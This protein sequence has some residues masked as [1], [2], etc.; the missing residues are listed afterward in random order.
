[1]SDHACGGG[2]GIAHNAPPCVNP[3]K[4]MLLTGYF[5]SYKNDGV[6]NYVIFFKKLC[7]TWLKYFFFSKINLV[8]ARKK[9]FK[10]FFSFSKSRLHANGTY[11]G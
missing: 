5:C 1:M 7:K 10:I 8:T 3:D 11:T 9:I 2:G 6:T 4:K